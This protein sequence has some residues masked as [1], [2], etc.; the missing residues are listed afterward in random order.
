M[1]ITF[2][3]DIGD[4]SGVNRNF[5]QGFHVLNVIEKALDDR[6]GN[7]QGGGF[8]RRILNTGANNL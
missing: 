6:T 1:S 5:A 4:A 8:G 3:W 7:I 2:K